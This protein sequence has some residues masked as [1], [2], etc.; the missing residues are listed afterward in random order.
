MV[1]VSADMTMLDQLLDVGSWLLL[2]T[3]SVVLVLSAGAILRMPTFYTRIHAAA[4]NETL[5]AGLILGGLL[6]QID[7]RW[8]VGVKLVLILVFMVL[9]GP[10]GGPRPGPCG[11]L[12]RGRAGAAASPTRRAAGDEAPR[13]G[14]GDSRTGGAAILELMDVLLFAFLVVTAAWGVARLRDLFAATMMLSLF[15]LLS[16]CLFMVMDAVD[17]A[18]T[19]AAVGAGI[20]TVLFLATLSL[21]RRR[22]ARRERKFDPL[23]LCL[24]LA[25]GALMLWGT[26]DMP[27]YGDPDAPIHTYMVPRFLEQSDDEVGPPNI[28]TS[29]LASYRGY[30]TF[31]E[32]V[33]VFTAAVGALLLLA[34]RRRD[35]LVVREPGGDAKGP[36]CTR[37]SSC[38]WRH[39]R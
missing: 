23:A 34:G 18:F 24:V 14:R 13:R 19:E 1:A 38:G 28:V 5:G 3:G 16:A 8:D 27:D 37:T 10:T 25:V 33:V 11:T 36:A 17:V 32:T 29:V 30:D 2:G 20:S 22:E 15:S 39:S 7:G 26:G 12:G 6:L 21:T 4:V 35:E 9:T 31:G